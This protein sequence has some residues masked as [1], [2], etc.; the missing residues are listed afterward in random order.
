MENFF[1]AIRK[2]SGNAFNPTSIQFYHSFKKLFSLDY[3]KVDS[4]NCAADEE[5]ILIQCQAKQ[6]QN[7]ILQRSSTTAAF[8]NSDI[9]NY[10]YR[11]LPVTEDNVF[12]Y[13]CGYLLRRLYMKHFCDRCALLAKRDYNLD[14]ACLYSYLKTYDNPN[15]DTF[16]SLYI[17]SAIFVNYIK[18]LHTTF[19]ENINIIIQTNVMQKFL[20][21]LLTVQFV[22]SCSNFPKIYLLKL[23]IRM[24]LYYILKFLNRDLKTKKKNA[25]KAIIYI[26]S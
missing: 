24:R 19:F 18:E 1:G 2:Q 26:V 7:I 20:Q 25:K 11:N 14:E 12:L 8:I 22:H 23:F 6:T 4:G 21:I 5:S 3:M 17:P 13:M 9:D 15:N 10:D 16:G